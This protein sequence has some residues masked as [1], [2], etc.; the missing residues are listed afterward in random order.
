MASVSES[1]ATSTHPLYRVWYDMKRRCS[2]PAYHSYH[3]YGGRG[4]VVCREWAESYAAFFHWAV[5]NGWK[6]GLQIDRRD[7]DGHY[8]PDNCRFVD[9]QTNLRNRSGRTFEALGEAKTLTEWAN[10]PRCP[11]PRRT[12]HYRIIVRGCPPEMAITMPAYGVYITKTNLQNLG[13]W[14]KSPT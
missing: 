8:G 3:R 7:N 13:N 4:I 5:A 12:L 9:K 6:K 1:A 14:L 10:D 2:N 11:V